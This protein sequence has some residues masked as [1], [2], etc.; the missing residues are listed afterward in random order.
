MKKLYK[1]KQWYSMADAAERLSLTLGEK[2]SA[3]EILELSLDGHL[4]LYWYV[5]HV[6]AE[7]VEYTVRKFRIPLEDLLLPMAELNDKNSKL[8]G[9]S[10]Y[11]AR[12]DQ[13]NI[14]MLSGPHRLMLESCGA[15]EDYVRGYI[16]KTGGE[17]IS[18]DGFL[19]K[20]RKCA[21]GG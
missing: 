12:Q 19:C 17:L 8:V 10:D 13:P 4:G 18:I 6:S 15:L 14:T 16:T 5:R 1:L 21:L 3:E 9:V 7:E 11:Y 2:V 20:I